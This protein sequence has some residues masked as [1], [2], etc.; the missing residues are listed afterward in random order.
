MLQLKSSVDGLH[1]RLV[2]IPKLS[3]TSPK[4]G[5]RIPHAKVKVTLVLPWSLINVYSMNIQTSFFLVPELLNYTYKPGLSRAKFCVIWWGLLLLLSKIVR[6]FHLDYTEL[7]ILPT[8]LDVNWC[9]KS[10]E[11]R[12]LSVVRQKSATGPIPMMEPESC[13]ACSFCQLKEFP[14]RVPFV[15]SHFQSTIRVDFRISI[16]HRMQMVIPF[17]W[18]SFK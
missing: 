8:H 2:N 9:I 13:F 5:N 18:V 15:V 3:H 1:L 4:M 10:R 7:R 6:S 14:N 11:N 16:S 12:T 17:L